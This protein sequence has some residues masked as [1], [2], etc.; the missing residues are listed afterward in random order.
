MARSSRGSK[1]ATAISARELEQ[2]YLELVFFENSAI[3][4]STRRNQDTVEYSYTMFCNAAG[5]RPFP[6]SFQTVGLFLVQYCHRFGHTTRSIPGI[7]SHLKRINRAKGGWW[8][9]ERTKARLD[10]VITGL[11]KYDRSA[12]AR[13]LPVTHKVMNDIEAA[14]DMTNHRHYQHVTMSRVARDALLRGSELIKLRRADI[15]WSNDRQKVTLVIHLSKAHKTGRAERVTITDYGPTSG[16]AYLREYVRFMGFNTAKTGYEQPLWPLV[17][18]MGT[19]DYARASTKGAFVSLAR[20]LLSAAGY[21]ANKYSGHS[22]RSGGAT[23]LWESH[24]CR[25]LTI[26]LHGRWRSDA[27]LLYIRANPDTS[28]EEVGKALAFFDKAISDKAAQN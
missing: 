1:Y 3:E 25:P 2:R 20:Q 16:T 22:Y 28:A 19:V 9:D 27:Y 17:T 13:K 18:T 21:P 11:Q 14:A 15:I 10:D 5:L 12:P 4:A 8:F 6:V 23:D 24:R 7:L 26:K